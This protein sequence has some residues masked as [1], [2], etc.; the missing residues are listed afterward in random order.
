MIIANGIAMII[1]ILEPANNV[2]S[3]LL[4]AASWDTFLFGGSE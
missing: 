4:F 2:H 3:T 1:R